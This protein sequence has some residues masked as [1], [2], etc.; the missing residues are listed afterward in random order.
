MPDNNVLYRVVRVVITVGHMYT[1]ILRCCVR[2]V[3]RLP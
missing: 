3:Q 2:K 1:F